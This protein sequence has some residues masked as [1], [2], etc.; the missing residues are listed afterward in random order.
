MSGTK[1]ITLE[2]IERVHGLLS[3][4]YAMTILDGLS[5][6][7][8]PWAVVPGNA[9]PH[10]ITDALAVLAEWDLINV[11]SEVGVPEEGRAVTLTPKGARFAKLRDDLSHDRDPE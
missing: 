4:T 1:Q 9:K 3:T 11:D 2:D 5:R 10:K 8:E 6:G 7:V